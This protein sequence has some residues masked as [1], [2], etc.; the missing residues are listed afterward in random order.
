MTIAN[1]IKPGKTTI[2][3]DL[4]GVLFHPPVNHTLAAGETTV[5]LGRIMSTSTWMSYEVGK[6]DDEGCFTQLADQFGFEA[7][8]LA[9]IIHNLRETTTY[10]KEMLSVFRAI[11][12]APGVEIALVSNISKMD[13]QALRQ[14]FDE[15]FWN[16]FDHIF[17]SS[18][19][20]IRKP[21]LRFYRHVLRATR[22]APQNAFIVDD[23]PENVLAAR[24]IGIRGTASLF[25]LSRRLNNL[26]GNPVERG[27]V[28]LRQRAG[29]LHS[30]T[31]EGVIIEENYAPLLILEVT[32][33][34]SLVNLKRPPRM[35][36]FFSG[37]PKYT[38]GVYPD[39][40]DTTSLALTTI[41]Y[42]TDTAHSILDEMLEYVDEDGFVQIYVDKSRP[43]VD[44]VIAL[45]V[46]VAFY[47]YERG[48]ELPQT[49][50][51][52]HNILLNRAYID[53][54]RYYPNAEWFLYYLTRLLGQSNDPILHE[55]LEKPLKARVIERIG[56]DGDAF[57]L[58]MRLLACQS[59]G[60]ENN[61]DRERLASLQ[62]EDGGWEASCMYLF[63][64]DKKE[65]GNRGTT[66]AFAVAALQG[67]P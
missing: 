67:A 10:D 8:D 57:C 5:T 54:T 53:G 6:L 44:A 26:V 4:G 39:D 17:T 12:Q 52:M 21:S 3:V 1:G 33:D 15:A 25:D 64:G 36:N 61:L 22:S 35:W 19:L 45:N 37:T 60:I 9:A 62:Q 46:L 56:V 51:W 23:R 40:L 27:M 24:S 7:K 50:D 48:Y 49:L 47:M 14:V 34:W 58:G 31:Q 32:K 11:K 65:I 13:Y 28:F 38:T 42:D 41:K 29:E 18:M 16:T 30:T 63:P 2:L 55:R 59:L 43:R 66:T 20:G